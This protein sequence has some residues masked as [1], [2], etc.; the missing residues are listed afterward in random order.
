MTMRVAALI[1]LIAAAPA[2]ARSQDAAADAPLSAIDWLSQSVEVEP[3]AAQGPRG[4][5]G[6]PPVAETA[7]A[8]EVTVTPLDI[9]SP[10]GTGLLPPDVTGLPNGLWAGSDVDALTDLVASGGSDTVP[11]IR[12]LFVTMLLASG[13][14]PRGAGPEGWFLLARI[15]KL[16]DLGALQPAQALVEAADI[17]EPQLYR[18]WFDISLLTGTE[19]LAC[20]ALRNQPDLAPTYPARIFCLARNGDWRGAALTLNTARALGDVTD[21]EDQLLTRFLDPAIGEDAPPLPP[22][23]RLSP[24]VFL[25]QEAIGEGLP[26]ANLPLAFAHADLRSTAAWRNE[27]IAAERLVRHGAISESQLLAAYTR[28][29]PAASGGVWDRAQ[30][31]QLFDLALER[32]DPD[33][34]AA[35]LPGA[36]VAFEE[37]RAEV[38]FARLF[39]EP[40]SA[41]DPDGTDAETAALIAR[42]GLLSAD[43]AEAARS[44]TASHLPPLLVGVATGD[45]TDVAE[46]G[47]PAERAVFE[48][49]TGAAPPDDLA[50]IVPEQRLGEALLRAIHLFDRGLQSDPALV[51][52][53]LALFRSEGLEDVA[54]RAALQYLILDRSA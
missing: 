49:F 39:T 13:D 15:D 17:G 53:A 6:D 38:A 34:I 52:D 22:P 19:D 20:E 31:V 42:I 14:P 30:A 36:W 46:P 24:L 41:I 8:P 35:S 28:Q 48:A 9:P 47:T 27:M 25:M 10:D 54:R 26:T 5:P 18:R 37:I 23:S 7:T 50:A 16:L 51:R 11:A 43:Y 44:A 2:A 32:G 21:E 40:L 4:L 29:R 45:M 3:A 33:E 12:D 1:A